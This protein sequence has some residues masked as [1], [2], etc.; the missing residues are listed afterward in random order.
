[1]NNGDTVEI[2][3]EIHCFSDLPV[4]TP[5]DVIQKEAGA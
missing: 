1:M 3:V 2:F 4:L 5:H